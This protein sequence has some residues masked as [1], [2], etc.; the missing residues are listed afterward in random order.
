MICRKQRETVAV[1]SFTENPLRNL[2]HFDQC[3]LVL[4]LEFTASRS[5]AAFRF[6]PLYSYYSETV[7]HDSDEEAGP[8][9]GSSVI[10]V[11]KNA[12][13]V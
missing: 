1:F 5:E 13:V 7:D 6:S 3:E 4:L 11:G 12:V 9:M 2:P 10:N 8:D